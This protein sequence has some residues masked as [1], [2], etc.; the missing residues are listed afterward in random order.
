MNII[1][2]VKQVPDTAEAELRIDEGERG[3]RTEG[4]V[5]DINETDNYA[6]EEALLLRERL[7]GTVTV[8][9]VGPDGAQAVLRKCLAKG[10]DRAVLLSDEA[11]EGSDAYAIAKIIRGAM[12][13]TSFDLVLTGAIASDDGYTAVGVILAEMLG[14]PHATMVKKIEVGEGAVR[15]N[16]ELEGGLEEIVEVR[17]PAVLTI[18]TG[19]NE[20]RYVSIMGIRRARR[21]PMDVLALNELGLSEEEVGEAGSWAK[22]ERMFAPPAEKEA[23]ILSGS[24]DEIAAQLADTLRARGVI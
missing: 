8:L 6:I 4:L 2:C 1:V 15:V 14:V 9:T 13:D 10:A 12:K 23:I 18:Q 7:G 16:R 24:P 21:K 17:L 19:I 3:I 5:L 22:V 11:F 20:P